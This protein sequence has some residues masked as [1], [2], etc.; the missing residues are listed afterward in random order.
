MVRSLL[1]LF[2]EGNVN[3]S[4]TAWSLHDTVPVLAPD[5]RRT[6]DGRED[7]RRTGS[8][9]G[10][11]SLLTPISRSITDAR[12]DEQLDLLL[13]QQSAPSDTCCVIIEPVLGEGGYI[14]APP[15]FL[16]GVQ[17]R[18]RASNMLFIADEVQSG[19]GRTGK[20]L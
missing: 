11:S 16:E 9:P 6:R 18:C 4:F 10:P 3:G 20:Y 2:P 13:L 15:G 1:I 5:G 17:E 7:P 12:S 14:P 19:F 8:V